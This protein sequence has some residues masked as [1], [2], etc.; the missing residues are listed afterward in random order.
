MP[1]QT[2]ETRDVSPRLL[3]RFVAG[4]AVLIVAV[5]LGVDLLLPGVGDVGRQPETGRGPELQTDPP[6]DLEELMAIQRARRDRLDWAD[7]AAGT[8]H[9]PVSVAMDII[10][11]EG[12][13][14]RGT[15]DC[16]L[17]A[18]APQAECAE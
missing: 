3:R 1:E 11:R 2:H 4:L 13:P 12:L 14:D 8:A 15:E 5:V 9:V 16:T 17:P 10:A 6:A 7:R 18:R